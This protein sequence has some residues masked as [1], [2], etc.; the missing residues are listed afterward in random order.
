[1]VGMPWLRG[2]LR[3]RALWQAFADY[4]ACLYGGA[5]ADEPGLGMPTGHE[6]Q[7]ATRMLGEPG[8]AVA[9]DE[10]LS[11]L[12]PDEAIFVMPAIKTAEMDLRAAVALVRNELAPLAGRSPGTRLSVRP[13]RALERLRAGL[14]N[15]TN[16]SGMVA[17]P[18]RDAFT[19]PSDRATLPVPTRLPLYAGANALVSLWQDAGELHALASDNTGISYVRVRGGTLEQT[20]VPRPKLFEG[21]VPRAL[22]SSFVW[23]MSRARCA[24]RPS[25]C[26]DKTIGIA[27][28]TLPLTALP[29][30]R[31][32]GAHPKG[33][34]ERTV[35][36]IDERVVVAAETGAD[37][38][39]VREFALES[40]DDLTITK[41]SA[42]LAPQRVWPVAVKGDPLLLPLAGEPR[43]LSV[44]TA[45]ARADP[46]ASAGQHGTTL[47]ELT[48]SENKALA[49][50]PGEGKPWVVG[51]VQSG[52]QRLVFG[53]EHALAIG[54]RA[55]SGE[56]TSWESLPFE[57]RDVLDE[58]DH[59]RDRVQP[60][61]GSQ[62][63][64][65]AVVR[66]RSD[67]LSVALC[68]TGQARCVVEPIAASVR[69]FA[70]V[71]SEQR[72]VVAYAGDGESSQLRVRSIDPSAPE[73]SE[74]RVP[75]PCWSDG[76]GFCGAPVLARVGDRLLL[77]AREGTDL[78]VLESRD[79]GISWQAL[80]DLTKPR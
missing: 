42:P 54:E 59:A 15:H 33:T 49:S 79:G 37:T 11:A 25:G 75:A 23:A 41:D 12:A 29:P 20:R 17:V 47:S 26:A 76:K 64:V 16:A 19:L 48:P 50:L 63:L 74:E 32:L 30:P 8:F 28:V 39:E 60:L 13:L 14:A 43:L 18:E 53:H 7:F 9:C 6:A 3:T 55:A 5:P 61:C 72:V 70:A 4:G 1:M 2:Y 52:G 24:E 31:W 56:L 21:V 38:S 77:G 67:R 66:E 34:L 69:S 71:V 73:R 44:A 10:R 62:A 65:A 80:D 22:P 35:L 40:A 57:L 68:R 51:C 45:D 78:R 27:R 36:R 46:N 58:R